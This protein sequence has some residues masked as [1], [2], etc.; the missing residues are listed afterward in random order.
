MC[1]TG[2]RHRPSSAINTR[3]STDIF[4]GLLTQFLLKEDISQQF[5]LLCW[6]SSSGTPKHQAK[7][8][9]QPVPQDYK[10]KLQ[11]FFRCS[12]P[13]SPRRQPLGGSSTTATKPRQRRRARLQNGGLAPAALSRQGLVVGSRLSLGR[14]PS[15][16]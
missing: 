7:A 8:N 15:T 2:Q 4:S 12:S 14:G 6:E 13:V 3:Q 10:A 1:L 9:L 5:S 16:P 11:F